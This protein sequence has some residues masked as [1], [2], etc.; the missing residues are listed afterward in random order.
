MVHSMTSSRD[1]RSKLKYALNERSFVRIERGELEEG[2]FDGKVVALGS[3]IVVLALLGEDV[4]PNGL[5][6]LRVSDVTSA[7]CP[8]PSSSAH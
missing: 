7:T 5:S 1:V 3:R 4:R 2:H 6:F 8:A